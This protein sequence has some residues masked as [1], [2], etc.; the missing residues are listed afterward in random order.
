[1]SKASN[2]A[3]SKWNASHYKQVKASVR[4]EIADN[5]KA[6]CAASGISMA[7]ALSSMMA[8]H[9]G[10]I[11]ALRNDSKNVAPDAAANRSKRRKT[12]RAVTALLE[13][14]RDAEERFIDNAPENLQSAP[15]Y[16]DA[17][18]YVSTLDEAI[19]LLDGIY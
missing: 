14:V 16:E 10:M 2:K 3:K 7:G 11:A 12:V 9:L 19:Q 4:P 6:A 15:V 17:R 1:M 5:F 8:N 18:E 13:Q